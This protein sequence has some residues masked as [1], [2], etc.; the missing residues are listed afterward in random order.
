MAGSTGDTTHP[1]L[2]YYEGA[3]V[4]QTRGT[5][6]VT[7]EVVSGAITVTGAGW[8]EGVIRTDI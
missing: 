5:A 8:A 7:T 1:S 4:V 3:V 2:P 6:A